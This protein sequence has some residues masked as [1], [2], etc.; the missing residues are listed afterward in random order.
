MKRGDL[1]ALTSHQVNGDCAILFFSASD[2]FE[3]K[4]NFESS[5][6]Y[7]NN[8]ALVIDIIDTPDSFYSPKGVCRI[9]L[10]SGETGWLP[11]RFLEKVG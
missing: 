6:L 9:L 4:T 3:K 11:S 5:K 7:V 10:T 1:V 8:V 2:Y